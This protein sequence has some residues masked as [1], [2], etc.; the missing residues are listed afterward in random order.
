MEVVGKRLHGSDAAECGMGPLGVV[1]G[2][3]AGEG[4]EAVAVR[5]VELSIGPLG[6]KGLDEPLGLA[7]GLRSVRPSPLVAGPIDSIVRA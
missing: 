2:D 7:V 3:P 1:V 6:E 4:I 5:P